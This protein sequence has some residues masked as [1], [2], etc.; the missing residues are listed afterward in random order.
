MSV[1]GIVQEAL[2][3][4]GVETR[5]GLG[6]E[7][8]LFV[9]PTRTLVYR[10][11]GLLR[12][13]S[14]EEYAHDAER[15]HFS[16][17]RRKT[18]ITLEYPIEGTQEFTVPSDVAEQLFDALVEGV[19]AARGVIEDDEAVIAAYRFSELTLI[20]TDRRLVKHIGEAVYDEDF[21][22]FRYEDVTDL[23]FETGNVAM[24][25]VL[26]V[27]G[28]SERIKTPGDRG[29]EVRTRLEN[30]LWDYYEVSSNEELRATLG[31]DDEP[32]P[33]DA[34]D[35]DPFGSGLD[36][37]GA[38]D[39]S[40]GERTEA[41]GATGGEPEPEPEAVGGGGGASAGGQDPLGGADPEPDPDPEPEPTPASES[42]GQ[43]EAE[44]TTDDTGFE[45]AGFEPASSR[46][47]LATEVREL[48]ETVERQNELLA[49]QQRTIQ[50]LIEELSRGR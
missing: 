35:E 38:G 32:E 15:L 50:Q 33:D 31:G 13:E 29:P 43:V 16:E 1:P 9:T 19:L 47:E 5:V 8:E 28:R 17:G 23:A 44:R 4:E 2:D 7:D 18:A 41:A 25:I 39:T 37:L 42:G 6:G 21:E 40:D 49:E 12:D 46:D 3:G 14:I 36:P 20:V 48:R 34:D 26:T 27:D 10:G 45:E 11:E 24:Q 30:A 22:E